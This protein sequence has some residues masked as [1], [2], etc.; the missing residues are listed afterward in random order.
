MIG[1]IF[2]WSRMQGTEQMPKGVTWSQEFNAVTSLAAAASGMVASVVIATKPYLV[3][4]DVEG[5]LLWRKEVP[6]RALL[7]AGDRAV[8]AAVEHRIMIIDTAGGS[9]GATREVDPP[10]GGWAKATTLSIGA[11]LLV[12]D[13]QGLQCLRASSLETL[14]KLTPAL[15][16]ANDSLQQLTYEPPW[17][18]AVSNHTVMVI[19]ERGELIWKR[20]LPADTRVAGDH[21][22]VL[23]DHRLWVGLVKESEPSVRYI[24]ELAASDG[25][26]KSETSI[27]DLAMYCPA[28]VSRGVL[29]LD[30]QRG[31]TGFDIKN[32]LKRLWS[33]ETPIAMGTC[34]AQDE[35]LL[36]AT[37]D[38]ELLRVAFADGG[39]ET[40]IRLPREQAWVPPAPDLP[41]G[42]HS[43]S[44]GAIEHLVSLPGGTAFSVVWSSDQAAIQFHPW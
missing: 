32:G 8:F 18:A 7:V 40:L 26:P 22:L 41:P 20:R 25:T 29:V 34:I 6:D 33:I 11:D 30:T 24:Y 43:E 42:V 35:H 13:A 15:D 14:W 5:R 10:L 23:T 9:V 44:K 17:I 28:H 36:V 31:L 1:A 12:A 39:N 16:E 37:R 4:L 3:G 27:D 38:G 19:S 21:P 2:W